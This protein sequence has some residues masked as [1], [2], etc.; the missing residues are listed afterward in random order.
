MKIY[1]WLLNDFCTGGAGGYAS[2]TLF[3]DPKRAK[4]PINFFL[5]D[6]D[7][8]KDL[9]SS[10]S[11]VTSDLCSKKLIFRDFRRG[12]SLNFHRF[13]KNGYKVDFPSITPYKLVSVTLNSFYLRGYSHVRYVRWIGYTFDESSK[14]MRFLNIF[15]SNSDHYPSN[16]NGINA[17]ISISSNTRNVSNS[18]ICHS[19]WLLNANNVFGPIS[20]QSSFQ[21]SNNSM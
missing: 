13:T 4:R 12:M 7:P 3:Y 1:A 14:S 10:L 16:K 21:R 6:P 5:G 8:Q 20:F 19:F 11:E 9:G 17:H 18:A 15:A 2:R